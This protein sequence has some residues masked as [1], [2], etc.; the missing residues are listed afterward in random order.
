MSETNKNELI[1]AYVPAL[2]RGYTELFNQH[3]EATIGVFDTD[4]IDQFDYLRKDVRALTPEIAAQAIR[5][6]NRS[7]QLLSAHT[8][9]KAFQTPDLQLVLAN[10]DVSRSLSEKHAPHLA[11]VTFEPV[12]LR[13][14]RDNVAVNQEVIPDRTL[15]ESDIPAVIRQAL[16]A[17]Q[18]N[19]TNW[20]RHVSAVIARGE[21]VLASSHN[22]TLPT[23]YT[24]YIESDPRITANRGSNIEASL[25]IH[26]ETKAI[27]EIAKSGAG[28]A[29]AE[30]YVSTFPCPNCAK[31][32]ASSG[33]ERCY[34][35]EGYAMLDG[36]SVL[37]SAD[38][39]IVKINA[40]LGEDTQSRSIPYK[41]K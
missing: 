20:W 31:L 34:F 2:H 1:G 30:I 18:Q 6:L 4:I 41:K 37:K 11:E 35:V 24:S 28:L 33:I 15:D 32:I 16:S 40:D 10:D 26:A 29:Q 8:L 13:W 17:E 3:P 9:E 23:E 5:G 19:S 21:T 38:I 12:F 7:V 27:A 25:D 14:D 22:Q 39:E 36:Y